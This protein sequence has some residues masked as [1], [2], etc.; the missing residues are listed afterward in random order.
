MDQVPELFSIDRAAEMLSCSRHFLYKLVER[1][2]IGYH[3]IGSK[4]R[5]TKTQLLDYLSASEVRPEKVT[6]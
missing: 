1:H 2:G 4:L 3:K 6:A 5:F